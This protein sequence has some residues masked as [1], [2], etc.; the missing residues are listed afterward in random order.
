MANQRRNRSGQPEQAQSQDFTVDPAD[1]KRL[2]AMSLKWANLLRIRGEM[3]RADKQ[4]QTFY[5]EI[6]KL[7]GQELKNA[8][9]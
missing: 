9:E 8:N 5:K 3:R 7:Q 2:D 4:Q 1:V 6:V